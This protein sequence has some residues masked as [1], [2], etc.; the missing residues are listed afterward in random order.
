MNLK[1]QQDPQN[2]AKRV[3][4]SI[5]ADGL[6]PNLHGSCVNL[7]E[8]TPAGVISPF[9]THVVNERVEALVNAVDTR[10]D[11]LSPF[12]PCR[13]V[14]SHMRARAVAGP[15]QTRKP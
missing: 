4:A 10:S 7:R 3:G 14:N 1:M 15:A 13:R 9:P 2:S 12:L 5:D 11:G 6:S 8:F